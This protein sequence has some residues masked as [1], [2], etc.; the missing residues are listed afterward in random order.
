LSSPRYSWLQ[1][2]IPVSPLAL[3]E[4]GPKHL[5]RPLLD[6]W[7]DLLQELNA[8]EP[9]KRSLAEISDEKT[10]VVVTGQQPGVWGGPLYSLYKAATAVALARRLSGKPE[11]PR[12]PCSGFR[13]TIPTGVRWGGVRCRDPI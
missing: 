13:A 6:R 9:V 2:E 1:R 8:A 12:S 10:L 7:R 5:P 4:A 3:T 11:N